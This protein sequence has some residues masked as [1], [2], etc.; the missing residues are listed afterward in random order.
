MLS[1]AGCTIQNNFWYQGSTKYQV[2]FDDICPFQGLQ[3]PTTPP[4]VVSPLPWCRGQYQVPRRQWAWSFQ[5]SDE[6]VTTSCQ[7]PWRHWTTW[8]EGVECQVAWSWV[9]QSEN[10]RTFYEVQE[11]SVDWIWSRKVPNYD[12]GVYK[13][14]SGKG[15][16]FLKNG[17]GLWT[18]C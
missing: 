12:F 13:Q 16:V 8:V 1:H 14:V 7:S 4:R 17:M 2:Y 5:S 9:K 15:D 3:P 6:H 11:G 10:D 18:T